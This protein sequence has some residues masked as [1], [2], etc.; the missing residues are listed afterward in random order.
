MTNLIA[1]RALTAA[2]LTAA[3]S[4]AGLFA[5]AGTSFAAP[6][7]PRGV[8][9]EANVAGAIK[10]H[11]VVVLKNDSDDAAL[12]RKVGGTVDERYTSA[13]KGFSATM[14]ETGARTLAADPAVAYVEQDRTVHVASTPASWG[15]DRIHQ[16]TLPLA[17]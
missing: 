15:L 13:V 7:A 3:A 9:R 12:V 14:S 10:D 5:L 16:P 8:V 2:A 11:Y 1:R 6:T 17:N 4:T